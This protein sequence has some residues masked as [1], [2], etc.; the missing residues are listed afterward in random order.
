MDKELLEALGYKEGEFKDTKEF[1]SKFNTDYIKISEAHKNPDIIKTANSRLIGSVE[2]R[3]KKLAKTFEIDIDS[4]DFKDL[5]T[6]DL[7][8]KVSEVAHKNVQTKVKSLEE[9]IKGDDGKALKEW[10]DKYEKAAK[11]NNDYKEL[12]DTRTK[13]VET[14]KGEAATVIKS[15]KIGDVRKKA[16]DSIKFKKDFN[17]LERT[18]FNSLFDAKYEIDLDDQGNTFIQDKETKK[19]IPSDK[20]G[21]E[22][23]TIEEVMNKE[24]LTNKL[25]D[26]TEQKNGV[27]QNQNQNNVFGFNQQQQNN[28]NNQQANKNGMSTGVNTS[29]RF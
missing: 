16:Y 24:A 1:V 20:K 3:A 14:A 12:L 2:T 8:D 22:F 4:E 23:A 9:Q 19:R 29:G 17:D 6:L 5:Q 11:K 25:L 21:G 10:Q 15:Y 7:F 26:M 28:N 27:K 18:G 13:E